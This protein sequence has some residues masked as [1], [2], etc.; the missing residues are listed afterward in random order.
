MHGIM[1]NMCNTSNFVHERYNASHIHSYC[2]LKKA[3]K[4]SHTLSYKRGSPLPSNF[5]VECCG[6]ILDVLCIG[7]FLLAFVWASYYYKH[8]DDH[9]LYCLPLLRCYICIRCPI[10]CMSCFDLLSC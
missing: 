3:L 9:I 10:F 8:F 6:A 7:P 5:Y 1:R 2:R 4:G